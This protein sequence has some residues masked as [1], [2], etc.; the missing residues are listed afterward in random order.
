MR[1]LTITD[2]V[3]SVCDVDGVVRH[4]LDVFSMKDTLLLLS[5][6]I[7]DSGFSCVEIIA[8]L[9]HGVRLASLFHHRLPDSVTCRVGSA[10]CIKDTCLKVIFHIIR[11]QLH[12]A[13][14]HTD[15]AIV[16]Y[17]LISIAEVL[18]NGVFCR[19]ECRSIQ[20]TFVHQGH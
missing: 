20:R 14:V 18:Y 9:I 4:H 17:D 1:L 10:S 19:C 11:G 12:V 5:H 15:I 13:V 6:H 16:V 7:G 2:G 8:D 3:F